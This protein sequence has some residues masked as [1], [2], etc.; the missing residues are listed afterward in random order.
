MKDLLA[1]WRARPVAF[2]LCA[3]GIIAAA[4]IAALFFFQADIGPDEAQYWIWSKAPAFGYYSKPP[5][6]AWAIG[7]TT[8]LFGDAPWAVRLSAPLFQF[9]ACLYLFVLARRLYGEAAGFWSGLGWLLLP[10]VSLSSALITTDA[11]LLFFWSAA[12]CYFF[13]MLSAKAEARSALPPAIL[14]GA[15]VGLGFLAKYAMVY[16]LIGAALALVLSRKTRRAFPWRAG[17]VA[18]AVAAAVFAPNIWWNAAHNFDT[19]AHTAANANWS[20]RLFHPAN[21]LNFLFSQFGVFGVLPTLGLIW[22]LA[23]A[24]RCIGEAGEQREADIALLAFALTPLAIVAPEALIS[25]AHANW[26]AASYPAAIILV[27]VWALRA[28][29][30]WAVAA[31]AVFNTCVAA[32]LVAALSDFALVDAVG[33]SNAVKRVRGWPAQGAAVR[34]AAAGYDAI[35]VD[36]REL[37][38]ELLYYAR[39]GPPIRAWNSNHRVDSHYEAFMAY[40]PAKAPRALY[41]TERPDAPGL[42]NAFARQA[43]AG[44][45]EA[46]L[47]RGRKRTLYFFAVSGYRGG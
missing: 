39:G 37:M 27:T 34:A 28:R 4:R 5:L 31:N 36:D 2:F 7:A 18:A 44:S 45:S 8:G 47:K 14:L 1:L 38:G 26:A 9:G 40:D 17:L 23:T 46:D 10:G 11:P 15:A 32:I 42:A 35:L 41:V 3:A 43:P 6:I 24:R 29:A 21:F 25:R 33:A 20:G 16:F 19:L 12:L 13:S 22:G 30:L